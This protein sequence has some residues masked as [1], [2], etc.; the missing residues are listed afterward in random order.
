VEEMEL[1]EEA[2]MKDAA[3]EG[4]MEVEE[5][6]TVLV[7]EVKIIMNIA[8]CFLSRILLGRGGGD[9]HSG[10]GGGRGRG[11][12]GGEGRGGGRGFSGGGQRGGC[13]RNRHMGEIQSVVAAL[14]GP[15]MTDH[16]ILSVINPPASDRDRSIDDPRMPSLEEWRMRAPIGT[17][18]TSNPQHVVRANH[19]KVDFSNVPA[20]IYHYHIHFY[21]IRKGKVMDKD[22]GSTADSRILVGLVNQL[23]K[24]HPDWETLSSRPLGYA[25]D[26]RS[27]LFTSENLN[28]GKSSGDVI[29]DESVGVV[30]NN[31]KRYL[32]F[33]FIYHCR[34]LCLV[35]PFRCLLF[36]L[37]VYCVGE[38]STKKVFQ[39]KLTQSG[40]INLQAPNWTSLSLSDIRALDAS[41]FA[42]A[43]CLQQNDNPEWFV[44]AS[45][46]FGV[47]SGGSLHMGPYVVRR[48]IHASFKSC[49]AGT[50]LVAD[51]SV[52]IFLTGGSVIDIMK[53]AVNCHRTEDLYRLL[54]W[55]VQN[56]NKI[57]KGL[58]VKLTHL[59]HNKRATKLGPAAD[60][61][62][63]K[64]PYE[65]EKSG[66]KVKRMVTVAQY[67]EIKRKTD[68]VYP[69]L[70]F[71]R[72]P[73]INVG[74]D[75]YPVLIPAELIFV[76]HG[77]LAKQSNITPEMTSAMIKEAAVLPDKRMRTIC[78]GEEDSQG[79]SVLQVVK[80]DQTAQAFGTSNIDLTP[81]SVPAVILPPPKLQYRESTVDPKLDGCWSH[82]H[83]LFAS[84]P[85]K[86]TS[87]GGKSGYVYGILVVNSRV[88]QDRGQIEHFCTGLAIEAQGCGLSLIY[89]GQL[90]V[91][92]DSIDAIKIEMEKFSKLQVRIVLVVLN[93]DVRSEVKI[94]ADPMCLPTQCIRSKTIGRP[95]KQIMLNLCLKINVKMGG[96]NHTV[97][98]VSSAPSTIHPLSW[99]FDKP[100]MVVGIDVSHPEKGSGRPSMAAVVASMDR[101]LSQYATR[102]LT[103]APGEMVL[104]LTDAMVSLFTTFRGKNGNHMPK[105]VV[106]YRDGVSEGQFGHVLDEELRQIKEAIE[107]MS[108][109]EDFVKIAIVVCQKRHKTRIVYE[110]KGS[111]G[112]LP[113]FIN[114]CPGLVV[115]SRGG[116]DT[117]VSAN[118]NEFYLNSHV[119]IQGTAKSCKYSLIYDQI[120]MRLSDL[121]LLTYWSTYLYVRCNRSVSYATPA[122]YAHWASKRCK[123]LVAA[124]A[125]GD[126]LHEI[127]ETWSRVGIPTSMFFL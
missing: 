59:G 96:V 91:C 123:D 76:P 22:V 58:K 127:S 45:A 105:H 34:F 9:F 83:Q 40:F 117:I 125:S 77:Q 61:E 54:E 121:E 29:L 92:N 79:R 46:L 62:A 8:P 124:G 75:K 100:T 3:E 44:T 31:G 80:E 119:A 42:F 90:F 27:S 17:A 74:N 15:G 43:R 23:R 97:A 67:Y 114:P 19:F 94:V 66:N 115:D 2:I 21:P 120:G 6:I 104:G 102:L 89:S 14:K 4:I 37:V 50:V 69:I 110:E 85:P 112:L 41:L 38:E 71:P 25:Y 48:G 70:E 109:P 116:N 118:Y 26:G 20:C 24:N 82:D 55:Q 56:T 35:I 81:M 10:G 57:I 113:T 47:V 73:T 84:V 111:N 28:C 52:N 103:Q 12:G 13:G 65:E 86:P 68:S 106:V 36:V 51:M 7:E 107:L 60:S 5:N 1:E 39:V 126:L 63:S 64:F 18:L 122:Y 78:N 95:S 88:P 30:D 98:R 99:I 11:G 87:L 93:G 108:Y 72:L 33:S 53:S 49:L 32:F 101:N 16:D